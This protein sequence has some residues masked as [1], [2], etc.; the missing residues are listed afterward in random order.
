MLAS[1]LITQAV[2]PLRTSDTGEF[3][4]D[5]MDELK[6]THLPIVNN[7][8]FLGLISESDILGLNDPQAPVGSHR[9]TESRV[10]V[11][12]GQHIAGSG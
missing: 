8:E 1:E 5:R 12:E 4:L 6:V 3:A 9:L 11:D 2:L 7:L 10:Y